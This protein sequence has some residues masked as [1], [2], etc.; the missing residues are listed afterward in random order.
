[1]QLLLGPG[2]TLVDL[3]PRRP[4]E[5]HPGPLPQQH[6]RS[7]P[8]QLL[9]RA[10][11]DPSRARARTWRRRPDERETT[12]AHVPT[13]ASQPTRERGGDESPPRPNPKTPSSTSHPPFPSPP[14]HARSA[15]APRPASGPTPPHASASASSALVLAG[16]RRVASRRVASGRPRSPG[17]CWSVGRL[18]GA[19]AG[20]EYGRGG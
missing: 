4:E 15:P 6:C 14:P 10:P 7:S 12:R 2:P 16:G 11:R 9:L 17:R 1:L 5:K 19:A 13:P 3:G 8:R 18:A 20:E